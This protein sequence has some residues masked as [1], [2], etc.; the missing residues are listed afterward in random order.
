MMIADVHGILDTEAGKV[1]ELLWFWRNMREDG[2]DE[3][4]WEADNCGGGY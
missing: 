1:I 4:V 2:K 3:F